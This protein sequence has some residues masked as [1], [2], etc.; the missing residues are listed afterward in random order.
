MVRKF[1]YFFAII[2][3]FTNCITIKKRK[4]VKKASL[5]LLKPHEIITPIFL[6]NLFPDVEKT[7]TIDFTGDGE[8]DYLCYVK[9]KTSKGYYLEENWVTSSSEIMRSNII[10]FEYDYK[11]FIDLDGDNIPEIIKA[12]GESEG[13]NYGIYKLDFSKKN[14]SIQFYFNPV[15]EYENSFFWGYPWEIEGIEIQQNKIKC[16]L[17]HNII[18]DGVIIRPK[19][20]NNFPV[21]IFKGITKEKYSGVKKIRIFKLEKLTDLQFL[22]ITQLQSHVKVNK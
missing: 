3:C 9:I 6:T 14:D 8:K 4:D 7:L 16:T 17:K 15:I 13:I 12:Q 2:V 18:R 1:Y 19:W 22:S 10:H 11:W 5:N 20:Q 21:I